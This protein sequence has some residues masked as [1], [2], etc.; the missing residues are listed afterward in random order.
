VTEQQ[1]FARQAIADLGSDFSPELPRLTK[2]RPHESPLESARETPPESPQ[3]GSAV[4]EPA[5]D[6]SRVD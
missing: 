2:D 5:A 6:A 3:D 1:V 4:A